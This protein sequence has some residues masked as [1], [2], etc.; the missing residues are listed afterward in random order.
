[1]LSGGRP[2]STSTIDQTLVEQLWGND[3]KLFAAHAAHLWLLPRSQ[4]TQTQNRSR[5]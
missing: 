4:S 1:M 2:L 5:I 3:I